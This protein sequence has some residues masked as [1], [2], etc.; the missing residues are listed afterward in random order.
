MVL[1]EPTQ[2]CN[3]DISYTCTGAE[4]NSVS[5]IFIHDW[6]NIFFIFKT[7]SFYIL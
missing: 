4:D 5:C 2:D 7:F 3:F 1:E 6:I